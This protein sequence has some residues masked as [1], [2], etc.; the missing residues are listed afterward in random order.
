MKIAFLIQRRNYYRLLGPVVERALARGWDTECWEAGG[1]ALKGRRALERR[2]ALPAFRQGRPRRRE[3]AADTDVSRLLAEVGPD[4]VVTLRP[5]PGLTPDGR[6]RWLGLQYT[7]DIGGMVDAAGRTPFDAIG[8][9]TEH[10]RAR[11]ADS[12]RILEFAPE[13]PGAALPGAPRR[14]RGVRADRLPC[15]H[16]RACTSTICSG[17][18]GARAS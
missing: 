12:L 1:E 4:T 16:P 17:P 6:T 18:I 9:H 5:P 10:W 7:L 3:Y 14:P 8:V 11:A 13:G 2:A 15:D